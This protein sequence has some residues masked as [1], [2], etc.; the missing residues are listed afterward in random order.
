MPRPRVGSILTRIRVQPEMNLIQNY[1]EKKESG[2]WKYPFPNLF[3]YINWLEDQ[4]ENPIGI[5][6]VNVAKAAETL[7]IALLKLQ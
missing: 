7:R 1:V 5:K 2:Y 6:G 3:N 4:L